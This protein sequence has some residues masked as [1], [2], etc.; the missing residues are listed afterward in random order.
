[1][2]FQ[3][4]LQAFRQVDAGGLQRLVDPVHDVQ[5]RRCHHLGIGVE[6]GQDRVVFKPVDNRRHVTDTHDAAI[7]GLPDNDVGKFSLGIGLAANLELVG[8][9]L[10]AHRA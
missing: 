6:R 3:H 5:Q 8:S 10:G 4:R 1:M 9:D 7:V 2:A